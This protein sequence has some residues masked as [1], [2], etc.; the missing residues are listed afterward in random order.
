MVANRSREGAFTL[1]VRA[2]I[3]I[4]TAETGIVS[5][6]VVAHHIGA[7]PV[8]LR[9]VLGRLRRGGLLEARSGPGGG[10]A[11]AR[12]PDTIGLGLVHRVLA[13][14]AG[15]G[16]D[17]RLARTIRAAQEALRKRLDGVTIGDLM[18]DPS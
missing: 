12:D 4:A 6:D 3:R 9:R 10:W 2:L 16:P 11:I 17:D 13:V 1:G 15:P 5:S 7:H 8:V 18:R 14:P